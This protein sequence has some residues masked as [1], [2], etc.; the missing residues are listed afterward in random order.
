MRKTLIYLQHN[1]IDIQVYDLPEGYEFVRYEK[2][3]E[4]DWAYIL[5]ESGEFDSHSDALKR[6]HKEF[7]KVSNL[8]EYM[9]FIENE[10]SERIATVTAWH[11]T[12]KDKL[13]G[14]L[15]WF[16]VA[17]DSQGRGL[18]LPLLSKGMTMLQ[19]KHEDAF[20][21]VKVSNKV[22]VRLFMSMGW[23]PMIVHPWEVRVWVQAGYHN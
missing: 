22:M 23:K 11:G 12:V 17:P 5:L 8:E 9:I 6:F 4:D 3:F 10:N 14:R 7:D 19:D 21:K 20:L 13:R 18:G 15:H 16:N 1:L 2:G